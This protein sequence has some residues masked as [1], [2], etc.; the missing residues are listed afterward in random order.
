M[1][2]LLCH[3]RGQRGMVRFLWLLTVNDTHGN[4]SVHVLTIPR[5]VAYWMLESTTNTTLKQQARES[6]LSKS[7][8]FHVAHDSKACLA[9]PA[10]RRSGVSKGQLA[11]CIR[12]PLFCCGRRLLFVQWWKPSLSPPPSTDSSGGIRYAYRTLFSAVH[13]LIRF[14]RDVCTRL[15]PDTNP[16][17][18]TLNDPG[19]KLGS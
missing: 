7:A 4:G 17:C 18:D 5:Y 19:R 15:Q 12:S 14:G 2:V 3:A 16:I 9:S 13:K 8:D 10:C 6:V 1:I 11:N